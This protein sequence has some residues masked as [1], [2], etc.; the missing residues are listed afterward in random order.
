MHDLENAMTILYTVVLPA[1]PFLV[2]ALIVRS[3]RSGNPCDIPGVVGAMVGGLTAVVTPNIWLSYGSHDYSGGANI[4]QGIIFLAMPIC[5]IIAM[6][7]GGWVGHAIGG[8][9]K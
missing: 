2:L 7:I 6:F 5:M 9:S 1:I 8:L 4:G 3:H